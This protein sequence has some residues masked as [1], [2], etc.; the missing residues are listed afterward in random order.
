MLTARKTAACRVGTPAEVIVRPQHVLLGDEARHAGNSFQGTI[1]NRL[2]SGDCVKLEIEVSRTISI[3]AQVPS[4]RVS[5]ADYVS[6]D[7][8]NTGFEP[9]NAMVFPVQR[10]AQDH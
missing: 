1:R 8:I 10:S 5:S 2:Y 6:G 4:T 3:V 9:D 7:Q